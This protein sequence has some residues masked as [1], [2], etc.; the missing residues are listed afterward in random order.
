MDY[1]NDRLRTSAFF[2]PLSLPVNFFR[3]SQSFVDHRGEAEKKANDIL[4]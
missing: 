1:I 2:F 4:F 3:V